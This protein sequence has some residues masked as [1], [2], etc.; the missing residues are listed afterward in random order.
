MVL[1][2][3]VSNPVTIITRQ[4]MVLRHLLVLISPLMLHRHLPHLLLLEFKVAKYHPNPHPPTPLLK[5]HP[6]LVSLL[7]CL[8]L[9]LM[10]LLQLPLVFRYLLLVMMKVSP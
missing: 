1:F 5:C 9:P 10:I 6:L 2:S 7:L 3:R 8:M 4:V